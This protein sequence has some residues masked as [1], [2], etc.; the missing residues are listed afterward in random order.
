VLLLDLTRHV[1]NDDGQPLAQVIRQQRL[2][3]RLH[4]SGCVR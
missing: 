3:Q 2:K 4:L 1:D